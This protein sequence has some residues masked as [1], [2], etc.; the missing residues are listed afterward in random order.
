MA[1]AW[2]KGK[3]S[4]CG[5]FLVN[6]FCAKAETETRLKELPGQERQMKPWDLFQSFVHPLLT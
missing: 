2:R 5:S 4:K 3:C 1:V 6:F